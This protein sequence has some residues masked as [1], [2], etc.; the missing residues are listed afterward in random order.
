MT[1]RCVWFKEWEGSEKEE[2]DLIKYCVWLGGKKPE[3]GEILME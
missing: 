2:R 1:I 3:R